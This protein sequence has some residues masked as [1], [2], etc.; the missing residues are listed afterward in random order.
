MSEIEGLRKHLQKHYFGIN[1][2]LIASYVDSNH[3]LGRYLNKKRFN[4]LFF[5]RGNKYDELKNE[6]LKKIVDVDD[7]RKLIFLHGFPGV[8]KSIFLRY[9]IDEINGRNYFNDLLDFGDYIDE[10]SFRTP[11]ATKIYEFNKD[12]FRIYDLFE[13]IINDFDWQKE[14]G[15][16][17]IKLADCLLHTQDYLQTLHT[18]LLTINLRD[19][20]VIYLYTIMIQI[21][22]YELSIIHF[23]NIDKIEVANLAEILIKEIF[24][25]INIAERLCQRIGNCYFDKLRF[26]FSLREANHVL[27]N[28]HLLGVIDSTI[29]TKDFRFSVGEEQTKLII[30]KRLTTLLEVIT[31]KHDNDGLTQIDSQTKKSD[32][33]DNSI[34]LLK[35]IKLFLDDEPF[36]NILGKL[37][38]Y[39]IRLLI[40]SLHTAANHRDINLAGKYN[41]GIRG[42]LIYYTCKYLREKNFI[43]DNDNLSLLN[44]TEEEGYCDIRRVLF[45]VILNSSQNVLQEYV[46]NSPIRSNRTDI[47]LLLIFQLLYEIYNV[48]RIGKEIATTFLYHLK[49]WVSLLSVQNK[50][51]N[52][53]DG[54]NEE[55]AKFNYLLELKQ[56]KEASGEE[57]TSI[58]TI[59]DQLSSI[60]IKITPAGICFITHI[61]QHFEFFSAILN[62]EC[63]SLYEID[64]RIIKSQVENGIQ[65][66]GF[67]IVIE[68][69][70]QAVKI[71]EKR[72]KNF[73]NHSYTRI[74]G[75]QS[76]EE[77]QSSVYS[78]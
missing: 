16:G 3:N 58:N 30:T 71:Q 32:Y 78:F 57:R 37:F 54:F 20:I 64:D 63:R 44:I 11:F 24:N 26:V 75:L 69:V 52:E 43:Y 55:C 7:I 77:F 4:Y 50:I 5:A 47:S 13:Q 48:R 31:I 46:S 59:E 65:K 73:Y 68:R 29:E 39:D 6:L 9:F 14:F 66:F 70:L 10:N 72:M 41:Y 67:E 74:L 62:P 38:N 60:R 35:T 27:L 15:I 53:S 8:G 36:L 25:A 45:N 40:L 61:C 2:L 22:D 33:D 23:D 49:D 76:I 42:T 18:G 17:T 1:E 12:K 51:I 28:Q 19:L 21:E 56:K 34:K